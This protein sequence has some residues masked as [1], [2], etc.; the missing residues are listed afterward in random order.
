MKRT[1][2][3]ATLFAAT[4]LA[5]CTSINGGNPTTGATQPPATQ[6]SD[7][8]S[9]GSPAARLNLDKVKGNPCDLLTAAQ[10]SALG[11]VD[12]KTKTSSTGPVCTW[13]GK[14]L[15]DDS[16]YE[17]RIAADQTFENQLA[18]S[19]SA[20]VFSEKTIDGVRTFSRDSTDASR[21]CLTIIEAGDKGTVGA[22]VDVAKNK[23]ST[24]KPCTESE[25]LAATVIGNLR[26]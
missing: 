1:T 21:S 7:T 11:N 15:L 5:G 4:A 13:E 19:R 22:A 24:Q 20:A 23:L 3:L 17:V 16:T 10:V 2:L 12:V 26:G 25:K 14:S 6:T 18:N 9:T 8:G